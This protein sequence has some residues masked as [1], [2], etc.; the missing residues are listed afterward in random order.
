MLQVKPSRNTDF[1]M[2]FS[3]SSTHSPV[4]NLSKQTLNLTLD[5]PASNTRSRPLPKPV[6]FTV[7]G[8]R[9]AKMERRLTLNGGKPTKQP[10]QVHMF[11]SQVHV[12]LFICICTYNMI[13]VYFYE[14]YPDSPT[15]KPPTYITYISFCCI[16][17]LTC[18]NL[19]N[20]VF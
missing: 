7:D 1:P 10:C 8:P 15:V 5:S 17:S 11:T 16:R 20:Y 2:P 14:H 6:A 13:Y 18:K 3:P 12:Y 4:S 9:P 19:Q